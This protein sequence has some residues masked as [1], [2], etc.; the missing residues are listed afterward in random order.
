MARLADP[1]LAER[2][3]ELLCEGPVHVLGQLRDR[4]V[5]AETGFDRHGQQVERV[6]Q[7]GAE[8][9]GASGRASRHEA[10]DDEAAEAEAGGEEEARERAGGRR[11][12]REPEEAADQRPPPLM[13]RNV[14]GVRPRPIPAA[15]SGTA[16][17]SRSARG[18]SLSA[19]RASEPV[20]GTRTRSVKRSR[21]SPALNRMAAVVGGPADGAVALPAGLGHDV[22]D[23]IHGGGEGDECECGEQLH[24]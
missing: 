1:H 21:S 9:R 22:A 4:A 11:A 24:V 3:R 2:E 8:P 15:I 23:E 18:F 7:L 20:A 14:V 13:A 16:I 6:R 12:E 17:A 10:G 5:E 19:N